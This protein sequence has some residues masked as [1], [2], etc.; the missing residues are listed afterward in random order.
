[1]KL[2]FTVLLVVPALSLA[3]PFPDE[4]KVP[5]DK[6]S[7][8][9]DFPDKSQDFEKVALPV[10]RLQ[11]DW[12]LS[13]NNE[14]FSLGKILKEN[15][16]TPAMLKARLNLPRWGSYLGILTCDGVKYYDSVGT[17]SAYRKL[18][19][20]M[21]FR[22]PLPAT[23]CQFSLKAEDPITGEMN[24]VLESSI[25]LEKI[26][27]APLQT[28]KVT[29]LQAALKEEKLYVTIYADGYKK[30]DE[31]KFLKRAAEVIKSLNK[32]SFP[33]IEYF[34]FN[35]VF[36]PSN[37]T[38]GLAKNL[39][40]P[41]KTKDSFLGLYFPYWASDIVTRWFNI[42]Y[43]TNEEK[44]RN[45]LGLVAYDYPIILIDSSTYW[46]IGNYKALTAIP[47]DSS[48]FSYL[49][50]HE[51]GHFFGLNEEYDGGGPTELEFA[52]EMKE[53]WSQN[54]TFSSPVD[55]SI[56]AHAI[57]WKEL[58]FLNVPLPTPKKFWDT[59]KSEEPI[60]AYL[61]GYADSEPV[62]RSFIP[63]IPGACI[64]HSA[65][66][67]CQVCTQGILDIVHFDQGR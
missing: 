22:Y 50:Y 23:D 28:V 6:I 40:L 21:T 51:L 58:L 54:L 5:K 13:G 46:G 8:S 60:G 26:Q 64:M 10:L 15:S 14:V 48:S 7:F 47:S 27:E 55:S 67:F 42:V 16:G 38:L 49:L 52:R 3:N 57:K 9:A 29:P 61:G 32:L 53:P 19:R 44:F 41:V 18:T 34:E 31:A 43:P 45:G 63:V 17:G 33:G 24:T 12:T 59:H 65:S 36:A 2:L 4:S 62:K 25:I 11:V 39:G 37:T 20:A 30:D 35:A 66:K 1:M 56:D